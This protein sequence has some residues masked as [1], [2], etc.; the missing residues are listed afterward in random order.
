[1][2][3]VR[4]HINEKFSEEGDPIRDLS[5]GIISKLEKELESCILFPKKD[6]TIECHKNMGTVVPRYVH[7]AVVNRLISND[8][9]E[10][11]HKLHFK[12]EVKPLHNKRIDKI[13]KFLITPISVKESVN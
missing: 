2:K 1:M 11:A 6:G 7:V 3:I 8:I 12:V 4:E 10:A 5:I 9:I 13:F